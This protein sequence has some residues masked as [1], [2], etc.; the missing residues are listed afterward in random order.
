MAVTVGEVLRGLGMK[1][2]T[3]KKAGQTGKVWVK[4]TPSADLGRMVDPADVKYRPNA[5]RIVVGRDA[6]VIF[7]DQ[8]LLVVWKP[9]GLLSVAAPKR[10]QDDNLISLMARIF[11]QAH[12]VHRLDEGT[13]GLMMVARTTAAKNALKALLEK[14]EVRRRYLALCWNQMSKTPRTIESYLGR[15]EYTGLRAT[16]PEGGQHAVTHVQLIEALPRSISLVEARLE[17]GRTHQIRI[18]LAEA[19]HP[20]LCDPLYGR[21]GDRSLRRPA[22]HS[23]KL[24]FVHPFTR[25]RLDFEA[26]LPDDLEKHRRWLIREASPRPPR[27]PRQ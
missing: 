22:L 21:K 17:S 7:E 1:G 26:V 16:V 9:P 5:P 27:E 23:W 6:S 3:A 14:R 13:S 2:A 11:G 20:V 24:G 25:K 8:H 15:D 10:G 12:P 4:G 18:H 19:K